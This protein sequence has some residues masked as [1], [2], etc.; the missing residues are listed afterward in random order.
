MTDNLLI[1][2][3]MGKKENSKRVDTEVR[4]YEESVPLF[5]KKIFKVT[6]KYQVKSGVVE[7]TIKDHAEEGYFQYERKTILILAHDFEEAYKVIENMPRTRF[8]SW[9]MTI[10]IE[11]VE[12]LDVP[13]YTMAHGQIGVHYLI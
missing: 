9:E 6:F 1:A 8:G 3:N 7:V 11:N 2:H 4:F 13:L 5:T 12:E 10:N